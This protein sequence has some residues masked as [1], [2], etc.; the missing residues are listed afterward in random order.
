MET[1]TTPRTL[2]SA[3][4]LTIAAHAAFVPIGI[5]TVLLS[6]LLPTLSARWSLNYSQAGELFTAQFLASTGA[7]LISGLLISRWGF[8]F[9]MKAGL[10]V[11]AA[12]V[13]GLPAGS[14]LFGMVCI[15]GYGIGMGF[16]VPAANLVVAEVNGARRSAALN[17]L[18]FSWSAGAVA[19]PFLVA[20]AV[21]THRITTFLILVA[22][23]TFLVAVAIAFLPSSTIEPT[24]PRAAS[25]SA[26]P[27]WEHPS[28]VVMAGLF[29][30]YVGIENSF[31]GWAASYAGSLGSMSSAISVMTPSFFYT[32]LMLGRWLAPLLLKRVEEVRVAQGCLL[33][34]CAGMAGMVGSRSMASVIASAS[35]AGLG[36]SA[37][38][39]I[40]ISLLSREFGQAASRVGSWMFT[41]ANLGGAFFPWLVGAFSN[42]FGTLKVGLAVP[43]AGGALMYALYRRRWTPGSDLAD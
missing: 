18:N 22:G 13:A 40:T 30:L 17:L 26:R 23:F 32:A 15:A 43:F 16:A 27:D 2:S 28:F 5:V 25:G 1:S 12:S 9:A 31:G 19:C 4:T 24:V 7:V 6:P 10:V 20:E 29:F 33:L 11:I 8:R 3:K 42:R 41:S 36:L 21:K 39:P 37:V 35:V 38:Y 14:R 34:A